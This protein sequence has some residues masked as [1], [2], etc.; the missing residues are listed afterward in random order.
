[1]NEIKLRVLLVDDS[2]VQL[3]VIRDILEDGHVEVMI[4]KNGKEALESA[5][6]NRP[7][8]I[9]LDIVMPVMDGIETARQLRDQ[10]ETALVPIIMVTSQRDAEDMENAFV[11]GCNDYITKPVMREE[12]LVKVQA[13]T[14]YRPDALA[15]EE[16]V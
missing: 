14:G 12:L 5:R 4:A 8:L 1:M 9:L 15:R 3:L 11:G 16:S 10:A 13:L 6:A 7:D 2:E